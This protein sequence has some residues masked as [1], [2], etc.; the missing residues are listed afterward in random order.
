VKRKKELRRRM[1]TGGAL[2]GNII[3]LQGDHREAPEAYLREHQF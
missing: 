2:R 1:G 3:E